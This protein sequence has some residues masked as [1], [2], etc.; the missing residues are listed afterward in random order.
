[1]LLYLDAIV[2]RGDQLGGVYSKML[3]TAG[4]SNLHGMSA[5]HSG[6]LCQARLTALPFAYN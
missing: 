4:F 2:V 5:Y 3:S 1:M 6:K